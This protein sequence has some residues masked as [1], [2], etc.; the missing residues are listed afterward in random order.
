MI[1]ITTPTIDLE[2][3]MKAATQ[4]W[5]DSHEL[6]TQ[7]GEPACCPY[8]L[9]VV[10]AYEEMERKHEADLEQRDILS[11]GAMCHFCTC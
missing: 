4:R 9:L 11:H 7:L 10:E 8:D 5:M 6:L 2:Q 3:E 1:T